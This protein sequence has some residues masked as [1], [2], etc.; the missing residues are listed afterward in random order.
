VIGFSD[1]KFDSGTAGFPIA[2]SGRSLCRLTRAALAI[3]A[4]ECG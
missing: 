1:R 3:L 4:A 2:Q